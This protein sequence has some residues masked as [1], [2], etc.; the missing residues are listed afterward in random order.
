MKTE[1]IMH[2][3]LEKLG[4][5]YTYVK[6]LGGGEYSNVFLVKENST[7]KER[8]LK[9]LDYHYLLQKLKK[10]NIADSRHRFEE[11][12]KRFTTEAKLYKKITH[13]NI[14][15][16]HEM[17]VF[18]DKKEQIEIPYFIMEYVNGSSLDKVIKTESP[19]PLERVSRITHNV[20]AALEVIHKNNIIHRDLKP[21]NI[22]IESA[23]GNAILI[24]FGIAKDLFSGTRLTTTGALLGTPTYMAPEQFMDSSS[25]GPEMDI[26]SFGIVLHEMLTGEPPYKGANFI[27]I[28]MA[29]R[30]K[31]IPSVSRKI[32]ALPQ[33][34]DNVFVKALAKNPEN[35][36]KSAKEF[37]N[38]FHKYSQEKYGGF[39][40]L[41]YILIFALILIIAIILLI[42]P[43]HFFH[44]SNKLKSVPPVQTGEITKT[45]RETPTNSTANTTSQ[46][47]KTNNLKEE[48]K[49]KL[50]FDTARVA[51]ESD[52]FNKAVENLK[53]A[54]EIKETDE[55]E[56]LAQAIKTRQDQFDKLNGTKDYLAITAKLSIPAYLDF[57]RKFPQSYYLTDL[58]KRIKTTDP[59]LPPEKYWNKS[60]RQ[61]SK[62]YYEYTFGIECNNHTMVYIPEKN[63]WVDKYEV[64]NLQFRRFMDLKRLPIPARS[65]NKQIN[66]GDS[67]PAVITFGDAQAYCDTFWFRLLTKE[68]WEYCAGKDMYVFPWG[69]EPVAT[70]EIWRANIDSLEGTVEKDGFSGT[71]PVKS[72]ER[73]ASPF[74]L[75]NMAGNVWEWIQGR[76][77]KGGGLISIE[78]DLHIKKTIEGVENDKEGFRCAK[79]ESQN[80]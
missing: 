52:D 77:L 74:G 3:V 20:L 39:P 56:K 48:T 34:L 40:K 6:R 1:D 8:A 46:P 27:E 11:I 5:R 30:K 71:A 55:T 36:Y 4:D 73:F 24:D 14:V 64:S 41:K 17:G 68:E 49:Y 35:R 65:G 2:P 16:I 50:Y 54:R 23:T 19:L 37:I 76:L 78:D 26:Y 61:N 44:K 38:A 21:A 33:Q 28:M 45:L 79:S 57:K 72:F 9:I 66:A 32:P 62:G 47:A 31:N 67:Y 12:K 80:D 60:I 42:D 59:T 29:H 69:N 43:F 10:E 70:G 7:N 15:K 13:P 22:M 63:I 53:R 51:L 25:A 58:R 18:E 75:V